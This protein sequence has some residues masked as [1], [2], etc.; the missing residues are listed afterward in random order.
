M[1]S[2]SFDGS[3]LL[4][5]S[6]CI[7]VSLGS[8]TRQ[9]TDRINDRLGESTVSR[10]AVGRWFLRFAAGNISLMDDDRS[11]RPIEMEDGELLDYL[12]IISDAKH[13]GNR[14]GASASLQLYYPRSIARPRYRRVFVEM[15]SSSTKRVQPRPAHVPSV[16]PSSFVSNGE[17]CLADLVTGDDLGFSTR[18][19]TPRLR[20]A[21]ICRRSRLSSLGRKLV[22]ARFCCCW[23]DAQGTLYWELL[24]EGQNCYCPGLHPSAAQLATVI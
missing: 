9:A 16:S 15:D 14:A 7:G 23:W 1:F 24:E 10:T 5:Q 6:S 17:D 18:D 12:R 4:E 13:A 22:A 2:V 3:M 11:G 19:V 8:T 21:A 20:L